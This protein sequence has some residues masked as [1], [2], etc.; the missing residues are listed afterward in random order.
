M[1][2][3]V[4]F[5]YEGVAREVSIEAEAMSCRRVHETHG[6]PL[7][8]IGG[9]PKC[10]GDSL[11]AN[12]LTNVVVIGRKPVTR[13]FSLDDLEVVSKLCHRCPDHNLPVSQLES[14]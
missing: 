11:K 7:H 10:L 14:L 2:V 8:L 4:E 3:A 12:R 5:Y 9:A 6:L 13:T 1:L